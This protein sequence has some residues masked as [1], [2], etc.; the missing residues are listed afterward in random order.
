VMSRMTMTSSGLDGTSLDDML[1][2]LLLLLLL[3]LS[4]VGRAANPAVAATRKK[5]TAMWFRWPSGTRF[6]VSDDVPSAL[7]LMNWELTIGVL[8]RRAER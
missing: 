2:S 7:A 8:G 5:A 6:S 3:L 4:P 1:G